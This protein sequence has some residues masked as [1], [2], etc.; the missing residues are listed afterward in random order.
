MD[1]HSTGE[2]SIMGEP[3]DGIDQILEKLATLDEI[4]QI[5]TD[6]LANQ[7]ELKARLVGMENT[8]SGR[9]TKGADLGGHAL[10]CEVFQ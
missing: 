7:E 6:I 5:L 8:K 4:K 10:P 3:I 9:P 2:V 1:M